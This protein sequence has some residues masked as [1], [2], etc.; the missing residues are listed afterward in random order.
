MLFELLIGAASA[1]ASPFPQCTS[2]GAHR[3]RDLRYIC[4]SEREWARSVA[5]GDATVPTRIL[6]EDYV[7]IG[8]SGRR[9]SKAEMVQQ[10]SRTSKF[11]ASEE[12]D[13]A[14]VRFFGN[15]AVSQGSE[16][17][18]SNDG[19]VSHIVW[20]DTWMKRKGRWQIVASQDMVVP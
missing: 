12:V 11:V 17:S 20:T 16:S 14:H 15:V 7:G 13:E 1:A 10:P 6:A 19:R 9:L 5:N 4:A 2:Q 18:R 3:P 8:S